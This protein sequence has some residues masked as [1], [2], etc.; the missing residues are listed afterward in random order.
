MVNGHPMTKRMDVRSRRRRR[1]KDS[2]S[3]NYQ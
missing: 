3:S 1:K 2:S